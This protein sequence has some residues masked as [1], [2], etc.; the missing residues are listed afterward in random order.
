MVKRLAEVAAEN[1]QRISP[2]VV[3]MVLRKGFAMGS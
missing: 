2:S 3:R 1:V